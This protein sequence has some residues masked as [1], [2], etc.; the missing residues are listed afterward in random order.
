MGLVICIS[1]TVVLMIATLLAVWWMFR[2][3]QR[4]YTPEDRPQDYHVPEVNAP[5]GD[6]DFNDHR[7]MI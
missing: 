3:S 4:M 6:L 1:L 7:G 2:E 5:V